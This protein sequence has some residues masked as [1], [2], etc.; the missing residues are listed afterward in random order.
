MSWE[1]ARQKFEQLAAGAVEPALAAGL[2]ETVWALDELQA[3]D[4][5]ATLERAGGRVTTKGALR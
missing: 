4:L 1:R 5:T 2:A 3:R